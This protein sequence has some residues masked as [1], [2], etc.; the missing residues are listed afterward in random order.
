MCDTTHF[1]PSP[2]PGSSRL[3]GAAGVLDGGAGAAV[4]GTTPTETHVEIG[5]GRGLRVLRMRSALRDARP[6]G[7]PVVARTRLPAPRCF[8][9]WSALSGRSDVPRRSTGPT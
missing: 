1:A 5:D 8:P 6:G 4:A 9:T 7:S 3:A 2:T